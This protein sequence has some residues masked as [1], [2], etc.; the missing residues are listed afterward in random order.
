MKKTKKGFTLVELVI[1]IAIIAILSAV[2]I[3]PFSGVVEKATRS[4]ALQ[5]ARNAHVQVLF[6]IDNDLDNF[7]ANPAEDADIAAAL[8]DAGVTSVAQ[9]TGT[10]VYSVDGYEATVTI[11]TGAWEI[12]KP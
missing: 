7:P 2:M 8:A 5:K 11:A 9:E 6:A 12:S 3:P 1:V 10:L 4:A